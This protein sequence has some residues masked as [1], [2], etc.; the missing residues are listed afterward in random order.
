MF[1]LQNNLENFWHDDQFCHSNPVTLLRYSKNSLISAVDYVVKS[2]PANTGAKHCLLTNTEA[3]GSI[4]GP[5]FF[6]CGVCVFSGSLWLL[7]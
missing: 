7:N 5:G 4:P 3:A 2:L 6:V 1:S